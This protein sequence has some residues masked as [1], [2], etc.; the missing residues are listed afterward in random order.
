MISLI[1][2]VWAICLYADT[3]PSTSE[4]TIP[5]F[6]PKEILTA[7]LSGR[8]QYF[9]ADGVTCEFVATLEPY[10]SLKI[11]VK[12]AEGFK[13]RD[14]EFVVVPGVNSILDRHPG[15]LI[16]R[17]RGL[18]IVHLPF[19]AEE[20]V[21]AGK[22]EGTQCVYAIT[23]FFN[24]DHAP[25]ALYFSWDGGL[26]WVRLAMPPYPDYL[27]DFMSF[28]MTRSGSGAIQLECNSDIGPEKAGFY[29]HATKDWGLTWSEKPEFLPNNLFI[30]GI[31]NSSDRSDKDVVRKWVKRVSDLS[32]SLWLEP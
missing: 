31:N 10:A 8:D 14:L 16:R 23:E 24:G 22:L 19:F 9:A 27:C 32:C 30:A 11:D 12:T 3:A 26:S 4:E 2:V 1:L 15:I 17:L 29:V 5:S 18:Q 13:H 28:R 21:Y 7:I 6:P 20:W 25:G